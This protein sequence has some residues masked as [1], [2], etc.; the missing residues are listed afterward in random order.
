LAQSSSEEL[1]WKISQFA[2]MEKIKNVSLESFS[3][4]DSL[5]TSI[6]GKIAH[7]AIKSPTAED[8][9]HRREHDFPTVSD[10]GLEEGF[11]RAS[12]TTGCDEMP[13][14]KKLKKESWAFHKP[15]KVVKF[16]PSITE[17]SPSE[18]I[19]TSAL[20]GLTGDSR[21]AKI[22]Q[23]L[24]EAT[25]M[26]HAGGRLDPEPESHSNSRRRFHRCNYH[27]N[28]NSTGMFPAAAPSIS[29]IAHP[30]NGIRNEKNAALGLQ[31]RESNMF[32]R[33]STGMFPA[34]ASSTTKIT[35]PYNGIRN[36]VNAALGL[37]PPRESN[38]F[39][40]RMNLQW[41]Q[42]LNESNHS[43]RSSSSNN[44]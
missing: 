36:E 34:V 26:A 7:T 30:F 39:F 38:M 20:A 11:K 5:R 33:K 13:V 10:R 22:S 9:W 42:S 17:S 24:K 28:W 31:P 21:R 23:M 8:N 18:A 27:R 35:R 3:A 44:E 41:S 19:S 43:M 40:Q 4:E 15:S 14:Y 6:M 29:K 37:L 1:I 32:F 12:E 2:A 25:V 16:L